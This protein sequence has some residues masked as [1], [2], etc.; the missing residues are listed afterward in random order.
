MNATVDATVDEYRQ[1]L[2]ELYEQVRGWLREAELGCKEQAVL[3]HEEQNGQYEAPGLLIH[4]PDGGKLAELVPIGADIL[5]AEGRVDLHGPLDTRPILYLLTPGPADSGE[6]LEKHARPLFTG[7][8]R[9]GWY[10]FG[11]R[12]PASVRILDRDGFADLL[13]KVSDYGE[14]E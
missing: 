1:R 5:G 13:K 3:L 8:G 11:D 6:M 9:E 14:R 4:D 2:G 12:E 7:V 10:T